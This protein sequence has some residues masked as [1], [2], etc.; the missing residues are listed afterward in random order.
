MGK[1]PNRPHGLTTPRTTLR[2][3]QPGIKEKMHS[4]FNDLREKNRNR[5][6]TTARRLS[7]G[8]LET[9]TKHIQKRPHEIAKEP[10]KIGQAA[11]H[12]KMPY[13]PAVVGWGKWGR[14]TATQNHPCVVGWENWACPTP[15]LT[16]SKY[17]SK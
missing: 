9:L 14:S 7:K 3:T 13:H 16:K 15:K 11:P 6:K 1:R 2:K 12:R 8:L 4:T 17:K 10:D 5:S